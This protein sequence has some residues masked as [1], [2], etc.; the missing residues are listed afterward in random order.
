MALLNDMPLM[1]HKKQYHYL[2]GEGEMKL[3]KI[4]KK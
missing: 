3:W 4:L 1:V 2:L